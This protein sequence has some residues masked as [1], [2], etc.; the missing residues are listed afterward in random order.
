MIFE[1]EVF[2]ADGSPI[3]DIEKIAA[4]EE[5]AKGLIYCDLEGFALTEDGLLVL[6]DECGNVAYPPSDRFKVNVRIGR[7]DDLCVYTIIEPDVD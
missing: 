3:D 2:N 6:L 7:E 4:S 1:F 5:W